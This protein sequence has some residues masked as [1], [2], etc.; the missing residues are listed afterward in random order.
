MYLHPSSV[1]YGVTNFLSPYL[2]YQEKIKT[3]KVF[4]HDSTMVTPVS[5]ILFAGANLKIED[6]AGV[7]IASLENGWITFTFRT[8][9]VIMEGK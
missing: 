7:Y 1:N 3:S 4:I 5:L 2:A 8:L 6:N 9:E